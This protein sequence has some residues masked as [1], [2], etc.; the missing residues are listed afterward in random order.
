M[1]SLLG[2]WCLYVL[3]GRLRYLHT[4]SGWEV[5]RVTAEAGVPSGRHTLAFR[6]TKAG[7]HQGTGALL[8]DGAVVG[9]GDI[10]RFTPIRFSLHG[11]GLTCGYDGGLPVSEEYRSPFPFTGDL[12]RVVVTVD[13]PPFVDAD[14]EAEVAI[15]TQ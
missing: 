15:T 14:G 13:G 7:E 9:E 11:G 8:M 4:N 3:D 12:D 6:F 10:P 5:H 2:G 1:G